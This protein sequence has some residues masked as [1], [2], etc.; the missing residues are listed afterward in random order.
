MFIASKHKNKRILLITFNRHLKDE[1]SRRLEE[2]NITN[3]ESYNYHTFVGKKT[4]KII[5]NDSKIIKHLNMLKPQYFDILI[6]D[7]C[8]DMTPIYC[9]LI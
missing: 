5:Q 2:K 3:V 7:E 4:G 8:Q 6:I 1:T 9:I